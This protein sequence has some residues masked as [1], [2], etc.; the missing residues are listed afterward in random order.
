M[1]YF[2][3]AAT[4]WLKPP[5]VIEATVQQSAILPCPFPLPMI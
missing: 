5:E 4:S 2:D 1:I 3:N